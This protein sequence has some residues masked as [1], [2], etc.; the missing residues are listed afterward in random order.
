MTTYY[1]HTTYPVLGAAGDP[2][3]MRNELELIEAGFAAV[4]VDIAALS[5]DS[6]PNIIVNGNFDIWQRGTSAVTTNG[7]YSADMWIHGV[8]GDSFSA[9]R[10]D[11][12]SGD[13][14]YDPTGSNLAAQ[15][16]LSIAVT[17]VANA[18]NY[19]IAQTRIENVRRLAS[20]TISVSFWAKA[21]AGTP[22]I[23][24]ECFQS[25]GTGGSP[26]ASTTGTGQA[27]TLS[28][29]W[30]KYTKTF[31]VPSINGKTIGTDANTSYTGFIFWLDA[32]SD[33][34]TRSGSI[35][36]VSKTVSIAQVRIDDG[37]FRSYGEELALCRRYCRVSSYSV[38]AT[39]A[40]SIGQ[41][42]MRAVPTI[43]GGGAG[44]DSTGTTADTLIAFQTGTAIQV[45][46]LSAGL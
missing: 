32:G 46:T 9:T 17:S 10:G 23:G 39:A 28:T 25:F 3:D 15:H 12:V 1:D 42:D 38:P 16:F 13:A 24:I 19:T 21:A 43:T 27:V 26:S 8:V 40:R 14:L 18:A 41:I 29:T 31:A 30:T 5:V 45:L 22:V 37:T 36:Q 7:A 6:A 2:A 20:K 44:F 11:F 34:D 4:A 35:G 33:Y